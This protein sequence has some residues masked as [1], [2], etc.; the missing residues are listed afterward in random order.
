MT[1]SET[2]HR[3]DSHLYIDDVE[4]YDMSELKAI[5]EKDSELTNDQNA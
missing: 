1:N 4:V 3:I 2:A 5:V